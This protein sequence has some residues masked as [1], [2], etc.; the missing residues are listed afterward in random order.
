[1]LYEIYC[2]FID[3]FIFYFLS[4]S[5]DH[6]S[7]TQPSVTSGGILPEERMRFHQ[8]PLPQQTPA[9]QPSAPQ[10]GSLKP[11]GDPSRNPSVPE[12]YR[13]RDKVRFFFLVLVAL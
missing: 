4:S 11:V 6:P 9:A 12:K 13:D 2:T 7:E 8:Q 3:I 10:P 1:M 5:I